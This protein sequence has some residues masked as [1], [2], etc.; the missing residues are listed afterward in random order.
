[1]TEP[2]SA[3]HLASLRA[4]DFSIF[5]LPERFAQSGADLD[6]RRQNL[7]RLAHPDKFVAQGAGAQRMAAQWSARIN[8][9]HARLKNPLSRAA[10][11]CELRGQD[12]KP[13][14][15]LPAEFLMQQ[16]EWREALADAKTEQNLKEIGSLPEHSLNLL[17]SK[18]EQLL[19][20]APQQP[21]QPMA[22][23]VD[24]VRQA[25]FIEK[26]MADIDAAFDRL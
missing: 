23:I 17:L 18:I 24:L 20:A 14:T 3:L 16:M 5:G 9:A 12:A 22:A 8:Q 13:D 10:Y 2:E 19:D 7:Q 15:P 6:T 21:P 4:T 11:L 25:Q 26:F 1:M